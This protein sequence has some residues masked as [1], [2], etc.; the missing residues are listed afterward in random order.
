MSAVFSSDGKQVLTAGRD[1]IAR[2]WDVASGNVI[3]EFP[4]VLMGLASAALSPDSKRVLVGETFGAMQLFD[5]TSGR[6]VRRI[7]DRAGTVE[8]IVFSADGQ[9]ALTASEAI[10]SAPP[11]GAHFGIWQ[12]AK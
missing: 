6:L 4:K 10:G 11:H 7:M 8:S 5:A 9:Q 12:V 2:L 1:G 3:R